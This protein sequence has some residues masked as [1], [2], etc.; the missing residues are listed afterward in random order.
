[1][2]QNYVYPSSSDVTV[3]GIGTPNGAPIPGDSVLI[4]GES[5]TGTQL[6][7]QVDSTGHLIISPSTAASTVTVVQPSGANL[8][9]DVDASALPTGA[10][11]SALQ[12]TGNTS[13]A[14]IATNTTGVSTAANQTTGNA[15]L[16]SLVTSNATILSDLTNGTQITQV[17]NFPAT[18]PVSGTVAVS[19]FPATQPV[20]GTVT[21]NA[22][23]GTFAVSAAALPLPTGASTSALQSS[24]QGSAS[25]GTAAIASTLVGGIFNSSLVPLTTG[26]QISLQVD[27]LGRLITTTTSPSN[28]V[29]QASEGTLTDGS[30]STSATPST[31]TQIFASNTIRKYL[32]IEN[33]STTATIYIN[34]TSAAT[35]GV[36]SYALL[37]GGSLVQESSFVSTEAVNVLATVASVPYT[38]KQG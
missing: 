29:I 17:S 20:S 12:T 15:S 37:P 19:N 27:D 22:G 25:A 21:A 7:V 28:V 30:G 23:T 2:S 6:P 5:P 9:V 3:T 1:M 36:G 16:A 26:Q 10:S 31:S 33:L 35:A 14:T 8:H 13:L 24:T 38:A 4:S 32:L 34:F 18:Q 11:T